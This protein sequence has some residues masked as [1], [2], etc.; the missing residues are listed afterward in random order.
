MTLLQKHLGRNHDPGTNIRYLERHV[1]N[2][3]SNY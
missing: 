2:T 1:R 3:L